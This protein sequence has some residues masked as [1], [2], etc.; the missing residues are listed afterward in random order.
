MKQI[1]YKNVTQ[2]LL[3]S[4]T[5]VLTACSK[6]YNFN[7]KS[8]KDVLTACESE[9]SDLSKKRK[10]N[11]KELIEITNRWIALQDSSVRCITLTLNADEY[12]PFINNYFKVTDSIR[13]QIM[14]LAN[15]AP[16]TLEDVIYMKVNITDDKET[17]SKSED[18]KNA[19]QFYEELDKEKLLNSPEETTKVYKFLFNQ[20]DS[21]KKERQLYEYIKEEDR[22]YRSLMKYHTKVKP[23]DIEAITEMTENFFNKLQ[24]ALSGHDDAQE[25][26]LLAYLNIRINRRLIQYA[27]ACASEIDNGVKITEENKELYR[28]TLLQP[29][30]TLDKYMTAYLTEDQKERLIAIG[31]KLPDYLYKIDNVQTK[32]NKKDK[33]K[34]TEL[35]TEVLF[36]MTLKQNI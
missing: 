24:Y 25:R 11:I 4:M 8:P 6:G 27:E 20:I 18:Y 23:E 10:V 12:A 22:C 30:L 2:I 16:R 3:L 13:A 36:S 28:W 7:F 17:I 14:T 5:L 19:L 35:L 33:E 1:S 21:V 34:M 26:R 31:K 32:M 15:T 29:Y 9:L